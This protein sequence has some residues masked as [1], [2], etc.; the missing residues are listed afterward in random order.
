MYFSWAFFFFN[1]LSKRPSKIST[2]YGAFFG[3]SSSQIKRPG[4]C[5]V[6]FIGFPPGGRPRQ[7][8]KGRR[9]KIPRF[10]RA[11]TKSLL[12]LRNGYR[13]IKKDGSNRFVGQNKFWGPKGV[14]CWHIF[15]LLD[16]QNRRLYL[17][18]A[19]GPTTFGQ[20]QHL[21]LDVDESQ[22]GN[23]EST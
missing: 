6:F 1:E 10:P 19:Y 12:L 2:A 21:P 14:M 23:R 9:S 11:R 15:W 22:V 13:D 8:K 20:R 4:A 7:A 16:S 3:S 18:L 5:G 17:H